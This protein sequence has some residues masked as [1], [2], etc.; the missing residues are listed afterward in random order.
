MM[1]NDISYKEDSSNPSQNFLIE[2]TR[3][4]SNLYFMQ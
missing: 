1:S 4:S 3:D 2:G